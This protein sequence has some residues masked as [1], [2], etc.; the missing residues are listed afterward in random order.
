M[1]HNIVIAGYY[2][3]RNAGD[4]AILAGMLAD[5]RAEIPDASFTIFS[6]DPDDTRRL[7]RVEALAWSDLPAQV[8]AVKAASLVIVGGGGLFN[9]YLG[10]EPDSL[11]T[12]RQSGIT[13]CGGP[14][15]LAHLLDKPCMLYAVGVGPL[16]SPGGRSLTRDLFILADSATV[17]D[18]SSRDLLTEIGCDTA[19]I[20]VT[21]DPAFDAPPAPLPQD[22]EAQLASLVRPILGVALRTWDAGADPSLWEP[23]IADAFDIYLDRVGGT[24][25][26]IPF[27][28]ED[29]ARDDDRRV[30]ERIQA[31]MKHASLAAHLLPSA[32][33]IE[34][35][36]AVE[37]CD[38]VLGMRLHAL[39]SA[40][41]AG[42]PFVGLAYD[43]KVVALAKG[44]GGAAIDLP[45]G[46]RDPASLAMNLTLLAEGPGR[47]QALR[48]GNLGNS[49]RPATLALNLLAAH[50]TLR[51]TPDVLGRLLAPRTIVG[52]RSEVPRVWLEEVEDR[53]GAVRDQRDALLADRIRIEGELEELRGT[54]GVR[55]LATYWDILHVLIPEGG[56]AR[57]VY[58]TGSRV[59]RS[60]ARNLGLDGNGREGRQGFSEDVLNAFIG[61][62]ATSPAKGRHTY[63][64]SRAEL[65]RFADQVA[66][67]SQ[68]RVIVVLSTT[69]LIQSEGQRSTNIALACSKRGIPVVFAAW[70]WDA[71]AWTHQDRLVEGILQVPLEQVLQ[72]PNE[73][74]SSFPGRERIL[75][76]EFAYPGFVDVISSANSH[77]WI[78]AYDVVDDWESFRQVGQAPWYEETAERALVSSCDLV[79]C[80][81]PALAHKMQKYGASR[82]LMVPNGLVDG[83]DVVD[84]PRP[85]RRGRV[86]LG[87]WG[88]LT[89]TWFDW[90]LVCNSAV[91]EPDWIFY[92]FGHDDGSIPHD[93]PTNVRTLGKVP[94][95][96]LASIAENLDVGIV[97]F[98]PGK[99]S[100]GADV[101]KTYEYL[102]MGLPVVVTGV[103]PPEGASDH[104]LRASGVDEFRA[105][106]RQA[107]AMRHI[108]IVERRAYAQARTWGKRLD[109]LLDA[110]DRGDQ[111]VGQKRWV[112]RGAG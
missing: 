52:I 5:L 102:A 71:S 11:L 30:A 78:T 50:P 25:L 86:T 70:K 15:V 73:L 69:Q 49:A 43:P 14:L 37:R 21:D 60:V 51:S 84:K 8:E 95:T 56:A 58:A 112:F 80:V 90:D 68:G 57:A 105:M 22:V 77:G 26:F 23:A 38:V 13:T 53:L 111:Q 46:A 72:Y 47:S 44:L 89:Q 83:I 75:L 61:S 85:L 94:Q 98:L 17:R 19:R 67:G 59:L 92:I 16:T 39:V 31:R 81:A 1:T 64:E 41:R 27:R 24:V 66:L 74:L 110:I 34:R 9:D 107:V 82:V 45:T 99:L 29:G 106:V 101:I 2:G 40:A 93:L 54:F 76:V 65:L 100:D 10:V 33:A 88:Y 63:A 6:G 42:Q 103:H 4:E 48:R 18:E 32:N 97:P 36:Q 108:R 96:E 7:H 28:V 12:H 109:T 62:G 104:V 3:Y 35:F 20:E 87:Y 55:L 91:V 79:A